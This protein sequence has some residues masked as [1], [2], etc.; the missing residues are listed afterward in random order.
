MATPRQVG[1]RGEEIARHYLEAK[2]YS[3]IAANWLSKTGEID[4]IMQ[5]GDCRVLVEVRLRAPTTYGD[6]YE[7]VGWQKQRKL[8]KTAGYY[9]YKEK[10]WGDLRF[11]VISITDS[12]G[13]EPEIEH[14]E[15]AFSA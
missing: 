11:D 4:L 12:R 6:G 10:Y 3:F 5:D 2:G 1:S 15:H 8:I 9:Q 7:T 13:Q 14:I